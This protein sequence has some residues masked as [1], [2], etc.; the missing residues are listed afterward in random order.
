MLLIAIYTLLMIG[1]HSLLLLLLPFHLRINH[2]EGVLLVVDSRLGGRREDLPLVAAPLW[3]VDAVDP[4]QE[5]LADV[6][7]IR[8]RASL[9][10]S[11]V[12]MTMQPAFSTYVVV[13]AC[14]WLALTGIVPFWPVQL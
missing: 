8:V 13:L 12:S 10:T 9:L 11:W 7:I 4:L 5:V 14:C 1:Y 2:A 3:L 6:S